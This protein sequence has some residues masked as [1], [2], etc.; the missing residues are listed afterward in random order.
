MNTTTESEKNATAPEVPQPKTKRTPA[1]KDGSKKLPTEDV[2]RIE[3]YARR[4]ETHGAVPHLTPLS[5]ALCS[6]WRRDLPQC[7][8][9]QAGYGQNQIPTLHPKTHVRSITHESSCPVAG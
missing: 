7:S 1:K 5:A 4:P 6:G 9:S 3:R 2:A 8:F